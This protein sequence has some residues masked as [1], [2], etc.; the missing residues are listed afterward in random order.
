[1]ENNEPVNRER[2]VLRIGGVLAVVRGHGSRRG[3]GSSRDDAVSRRA[4]RAIPLAVRRVH[5]P[6]KHLACRHRAAHV[7]PGLKN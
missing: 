7:V 3:C 6:A 1:M 4:P 5:H 2:L